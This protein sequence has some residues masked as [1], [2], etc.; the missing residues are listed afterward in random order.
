M[1]GVATVRAYLDLCRVS[2]LPTVWTNVAAAA[3]LADAA[4]PPGSLFLLVLSLSSFYL[5]GMAL[6]DLCDRYYDEAHRPSR[7]LPSGQIAI[8][9]AVR[10]TSFLVGIGFGALTFAPHKSALLWGVVLCAA[11]AVYDMHHKGNPFSVLIMGSCRFLLF[12]VVSIALSGHLPPQ[13][14]LAGLGQFAYVVAISVAARCES[15]RGGSSFPLIPL[16]LAGISLLDGIF[17]ALFLKPIWLLCGAGGF[18]L[19]LAGQRFVRGD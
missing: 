7:P 3:F 1:G 4:P 16:M 14:A 6:N 10:L 11:I 19:T 18:F 9:D 8:G 13:V 2:N 12:A 5:A 15:A 17:L